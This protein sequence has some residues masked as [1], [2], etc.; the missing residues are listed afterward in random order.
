MF[1]GYLWVEGKCSKGFEVYMWVD[2][3]VGFVQLVALLLLQTEI[4]AE[5]DNLRTRQRVWVSV[6]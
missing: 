5:F 1:C 6:A 4:R 3:A 2:L